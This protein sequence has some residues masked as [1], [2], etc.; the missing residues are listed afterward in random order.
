MIYIPIYPIIQLKYSYNLYGR[1]YLCNKSTYEVVSSCSSTFQYNIPSIR[2]LKCRRLNRNFK[3]QV[4][5]SYRVSKVDW[6]THKLR[7][8]E[9]GDN[10]HYLMSSYLFALYYQILLVILVTEKPPSCTTGSHTFGTCLT[11]LDQGM[12]LRWWTFQCIIV[13]HILRLLFVENLL[14][15]TQFITLLTVVHIC[16]SSCDSSTHIDNVCSLLLMW[17]LACTSLNPW[18]YLFEIEFIY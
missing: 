12:F 11:S 6:G 1:C 5:T 18:D 2:S 7:W 9:W 3:S 15:T 10:L 14:D 8:N 17:G 13:C 16:G 4:C